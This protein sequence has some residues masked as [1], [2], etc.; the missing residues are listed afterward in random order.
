MRAGPANQSASSVVAATSTFADTIA[1][2][3]SSTGEGR[4]ALR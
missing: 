4:N 1:Y 2:G 3:S